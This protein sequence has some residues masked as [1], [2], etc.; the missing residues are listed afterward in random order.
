MH[1]RAN[2]PTA[3]EVSPELPPQQVS[4]EVDTARQGEYWRWLGLGLLL[5]A[6][7]LFDGWQ[8]GA[9]WHRGYEV[10]TLYSQRAA[11]EALGRHLTLEIES[12]RSPAQIERLARTELHMVAPGPND[13]IVIERVLA[14]QPPPSSV[15]ASR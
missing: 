15:V 12:L 13:S 2:T 10:E 3:F 5:L 9:V 6:A 1:C 11:E 4:L 7:A 14:P 8:R